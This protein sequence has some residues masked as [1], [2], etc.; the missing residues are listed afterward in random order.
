MDS[1]RLPS[2][3]VGSPQD[4]WWVDNPPSHILTNQSSSALTVRAEVSEKK[5][6]FQPVLAHPSNCGLL[7]NFVRAQVSYAGALAC[8][9]VSPSA[10]AAHTSAISSVHWFELRGAATGITS[11]VDDMGC[12]LNGLCVTSECVCDKGEEHC[13]SLT[14]RGH[15]AKDLC[16]YL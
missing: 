10:P 4:N 7:L 13:L 1:V 5:S 11:C 2:W 3:V 12:E 9:D 16:L 15:S 14:F 6:I 8:V